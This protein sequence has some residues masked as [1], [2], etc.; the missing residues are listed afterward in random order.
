MTVGYFLHMNYKLKM[1]SNYFE[2]F[3]RSVADFMPF[4]IKMLW[5]GFHELGS[6]V[7]PC[8]IQFHVITDHSITG[9]YCNQKPSTP[10]LYP[11]PSYTG[12]CH[13]IARLYMVAQQQMIMRQLSKEIH[14]SDNKPRSFLDI[15][16]LSSAGVFRE[17]RATASQVSSLA[18]YVIWRL[19]T[20]IW[21]ELHAIN[22][23][24]SP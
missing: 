7:W 14:K 3:D 1:R 4:H 13:K 16:W 5:C 23:G 6:K 2:K 10:T 17:R 19:K 24:I 9:A 20:N 8:Y 21:K 22:G 12:L 11:L 18:G 15:V